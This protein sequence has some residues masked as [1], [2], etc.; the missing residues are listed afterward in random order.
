MPSEAGGR[1][2]QAGCVWLSSCWISPILR[3]GKYVYWGSCCC[4][5]LQWSVEEYSRR[6]YDSHCLRAHCV[7]FKLVGQVGRQIQAQSLLCTVYSHAWLQSVCLYTS[8]FMLRKHVTHL[9]VFFWVVH[10]FVAPT[11]LCCCFWSFVKDQLYC[12][13]HTEKICGKACELCTYSYIKSYSWRHFF[14]ITTEKPLQL[15]IFSSVT[16]PFLANGLFVES[17]R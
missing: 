9:C 14:Y 6:T 11:C 7:A 16:N 13:V 3:A 1:S 8:Q 2:L 15:H 17:I 12:A 10:T 5:L 4:C